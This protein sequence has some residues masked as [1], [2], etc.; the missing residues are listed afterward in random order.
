ME[1]KEY[2]KIYYNGEKHIK[3]AEILAANNMYGFAISHL[4]L[5]IEELIKYQ[6]V[7]TSTVNKY[8]FEKEID[9]PKGKTI[10]KDHLTKHRLI[11]EFQES[12]SQ[13][14]AGKYLQILIARL[15]GL[16]STENSSYVESNR[17]KEWGLFFAHSGS[18][19]NI[20]DNE[21]D[22][23]FE[24]LKQAND[25]KNNG[26]YANRVDAV[27]ITPERFTAA[28]FEKILMYANCIL[29]QT[30]F[31]KSVDLD[32]DEFEA[33]QNQQMPDNS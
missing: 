31:M 21:R 28:D 8:E 25:N 3:C 9:S 20:P 24:W 17:F 33:L 12:V 6:V 18:E 29:M 4:I 27:I 15:Q 11:K 19:M 22:N 32:D 30:A 1:K 14:F 13:E 7:M 2:D 10:F 26:F 16:N 23:F 5:G